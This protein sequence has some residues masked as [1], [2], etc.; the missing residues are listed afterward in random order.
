MTKKQLCNVHNGSIY[1]LC[2]TP[3]EN[4]VH[5]ANLKNCL[6]NKRLEEFANEGHPDQF[7]LLFLQKH[8][9]NKLMP[10]F[11]GYNLQGFELYSLCLD[12]HGKLAYLITSVWVNSV[13]DTAADEYG[14]DKIISLGF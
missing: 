5:M 6:L 1:W 2:H 11:T 4:V 7:W 12:W 3:F 9:E 10:A 8:D 13:V 14:D